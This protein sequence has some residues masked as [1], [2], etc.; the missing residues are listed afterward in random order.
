[1]TN[2]KGIKFLK[3]SENKYIGF[4]WGLKFKL[5]SNLAKYEFQCA[6]FPMCITATINIL[7]PHAFKFE[8][9]HILYV[10]IE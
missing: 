9:Q 6:F 3:I 4:K 2:R 5:A 8:F 1:L 10:D 7:E